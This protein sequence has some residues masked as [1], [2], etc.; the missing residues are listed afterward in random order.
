MKSKHILLL[1]FF[2]LA[3]ISCSKRSDQATV[4]KVAHI[5]DPLTAVN[6]R[7]SFKWLENVVEQFQK[8]HPNLRIEFEL[9]KWDEIDTKSMAD[10]RAG[11]S[12]DVIWSSPQLM[13][14]HSMVGDLIDLSEYVKTLP[15]PD[16]QDLNWSAAWKA[17]EVNG[18]LLGLPLGIHARTVA[19]RRDLFSQAGLNPDQPPKTLEEILDVAKRLTKDTDGDGKTDVWG[20]GMYFG[21]MRAVAEIYFAP[22]LWHFGGELWDA[23]TKKA[24]FASSAGVKAAQFL[25]DLVFVHKV[26]PEWSLMGTYDDVILRPF[27]DGRCA[28]AWGWGTYWIQPLEDK[29]W[30]VNLFPPKPDGRAT[31][32]DVFVTPTAEQLQFVN[33]WSVSIHKL[34]QHPKESFEFIT[35]LLAPQTLLAFPDAG[36]PARRSLWQRPE[37]KTPFYQ[38]WHQAVEH[39]KAMPPTPYYMELAQNISAAMQEI[40]TQ[41]KPIAETL[42]K[43]QDEYNARFSIP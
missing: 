18:Q 42:Q 38:T 9:L 20:L 43:F 1:F 8:E 40:L 3:F 15:E 23:S 2:F 5:Y 11:I 22:L 25:S 37:L 29:G 27:L 32:A 26:T 41:R 28:M 16:L 12:H 7:E 19:Y 39:G 31:T 10:Y 30:I 14:Q 4:I 24:S 21:S 35:H 34:S 6:T 33:T 17:G 36:L 13:A